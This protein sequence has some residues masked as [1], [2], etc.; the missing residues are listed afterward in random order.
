MTTRPFSRILAALALVAAA[1]VTHASGAHAEVKPPAG[2]SSWPTRLVFVHD[3]TGDPQVTEAAAAWTRLG[4]V[5]VEPTA[6]PCLKGEACIEVTRAWLPGH[7]GGVTPLTASD[8]TMLTATVKLNYAYE[9]WAAGGIPAGWE[10]GII[11]HEMGHALG[12][13][14]APQGTCALM[15]PVDCGAFAPTAYDAWMLQ[16]AYASR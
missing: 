7:I 9:P 10:L 14:H 15:A 5:D 2:A 1:A 6:Y 8:G 3:Q 4:V 11:E 12:L 13:P 16:E